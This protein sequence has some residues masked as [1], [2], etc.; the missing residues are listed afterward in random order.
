M[1][2]VNAYRQLRGTC[3]IQSMH[4]VTLVL[5]SAGISAGQAPVWL[6]DNR[7]R[8]GVTFGSDHS[9]LWI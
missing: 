5:V 2:F 9:C 1:P 3:K 6:G 4:E 8:V 7:A